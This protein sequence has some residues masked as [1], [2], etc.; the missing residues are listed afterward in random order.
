MRFG[1]H[2][3]THLM[4]EQQPRTIRQPRTRAQRT[5][6]AAPSNG[7]T[8]RAPRT[9]RTPRAPQATPG[10]TSQN[11][12]TQ[13]IPP[14]EVVDAAAPSAREA[15]VQPAT[16]RVSRGGGGISPDNTVFVSL[17]FEGPDIYSMAGGLGTRVT[18]FTESLAQL[19]YETY[20]IFVGDPNKPAAEDLVNGQLH[21]RR[22]GQ[23]I[24][25]HYPNG[26]YDGEE[27][28]LYDYNESVPFF[29]YDQIVRPAEEQGKI[30]VIIGEDW[31]TAET[32]I[33]TSDMLHWHNLRHNCI[34]M[35]NCNSLMSLHRINWQKLNF[36]SAITTV[37]RYMK[38]RLWEYGVN[39]L[40]IPNGIPQRYLNAVNAR[41]IRALRQAAQRGNPDRLFLFKIGRF[42]PDK[43]WLMAIEAASR[44]KYSG[45]PITM[46]IRGGIEPHG[47]EVLG[48]ARYLGLTVRDI[49]AKRPTPEDCIKLLREAGEADIYNLRFFVPEEFVRM[50]YA[51][52]DA[53]LANSGHEPFGLVGLE[54][55][56]ARG[57]AFTGSTGEDYA[58]SFENAVA[59]ETEDPDEIVG[60]L[61]HLLRHPE[62][63]EKIRA[64]GWQT[65]AEFTWPEAIENLAGKLGYLARKQSIVLE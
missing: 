14:E 37:S 52:S 29:V 51:A 43:R 6:A 60:Y 39:A 2:R 44:L 62:E 40:T 5:P 49:E 24:S 26:V 56:A 34:L 17:C 27:H 57:I 33:R 58:V 28:K 53:T 12:A 45:H 50:C 25:R 55:M 61:L 38:H 35:W 13:P 63:N 4:T 16:P 1:Y 31:H 64:A 15:T 47:G 19:G 22:W 48:R 3:K 59:L 32:M 9:P 54:V 10:A 20:L 18:E 8:P 21:L 23:W 41:S 7:A 36:T 46:V 42:D 30:V 11:D 65:A